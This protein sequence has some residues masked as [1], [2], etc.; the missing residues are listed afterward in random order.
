MN[1][2]KVL[3]LSLMLALTGSV[4]AIALSNDTKHEEESC[5]IA[6]K[7]KAHN[8]CK[9]GA[10]CCKE[11]ATCCKKSHGQKTSSKDNNHSCCVEGASCCKGG[12][13][14]KGNK[15]QAKRR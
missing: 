3:A 1:T 14:C 13:C 5:T 9:E 11:G 12:S 8:C 4:Y 2:I 10:S 7:E 6:D 15:Q